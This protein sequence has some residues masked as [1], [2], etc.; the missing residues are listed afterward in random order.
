M[1][2][3]GQALAVRTK[4]PLPPAQTNYHWGAVPRRLTAKGASSL[5]T[6][7]PAA[8]R[9]CRGFRKIAVSGSEHPI[10]RMAKL[11]S[12]CTSLAGPEP[13]EDRCLAPEAAHLRKGSVTR[14]GTAPCPLCSVKRVSIHAKE[15]AAPLNKAHAALG[16]VLRS[17]S[18]IFASFTRTV[19]P[20]PPRTADK[21]M[22]NGL[23][24][25]RKR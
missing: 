1:I 13:G 15:H 6:P 7:R 16:S 17:L 25:V 23:R 9:N 10:A 19:V 18:T 24:G 22:S 3:P 4:A 8:T 12:Q 5:R 21:G 14:P 20:R 2:L 11:A